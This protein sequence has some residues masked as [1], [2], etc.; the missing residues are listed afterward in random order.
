MV[1]LRRSGSLRLVDDVVRTYGE[2]LGSA[3]AKHVR[4]AVKQL[5][6]AGR[7]S[8]NGVGDFWDRRITLL[9]G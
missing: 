5:Y 7:I 4:A 6:K 8:D 1:E 3:R 9:E 2:M